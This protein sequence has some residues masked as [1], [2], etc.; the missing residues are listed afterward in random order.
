MWN[1]ATLCE[2]LIAIQLALAEDTLEHL[3]QMVEA[4]HL[5]LNAWI[6]AGVQAEIAPLRQ[7][8][9]LHWHTLALLQQHQHSLHGKM[10]AGHHGGR[11]A[12]AYLS[13]RPS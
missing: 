6:N 1:I 9:D 12:R 11:A 7:L 10:Q 3:P 4:Y 13:S 2:E 5:H 8:R